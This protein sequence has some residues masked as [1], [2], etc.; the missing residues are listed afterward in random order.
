VREKT[1]TLEVSMIQFDKGIPAPR[2][3]KYEFLDQMEIGDSY[4]LPTGVNIYCV[5]ASMVHQTQR[6]GKKFSRKRQTNGAYR[7]WRVK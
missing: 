3:K 4:L 6:Y 2:H 7:I 1:L 5:S